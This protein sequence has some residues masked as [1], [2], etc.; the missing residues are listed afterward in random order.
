MED[1]ATAP[2]TKNILIHGP[3]GQQDDGS[4][5]ARRTVTGV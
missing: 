3:S 4:P 5:E 2:A 1:I